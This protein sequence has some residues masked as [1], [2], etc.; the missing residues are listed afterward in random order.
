MHK[1]DVLV[2]ISSKSI[3]FKHCRIL[4]GWNNDDPTATGIQIMAL[5]V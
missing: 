5:K 2:N 4:I 1:A 3:G